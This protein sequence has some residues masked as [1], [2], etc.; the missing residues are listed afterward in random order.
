[1]FRL[2]HWMLK[3][4]NVVGNFRNI[5][6]VTLW[7][8]TVTVP[9]CAVCSTAQNVQGCLQTLS[10][11]ERSSDPLFSQWW[12]AT[13]QHFLNA[14][15]KWAG[16]HRVVPDSFYEQEWISNRETTPSIQLIIYVQSLISHLFVKCL[17]SFTH[18]FWQSPYLWQNDSGSCWSVVTPWVIHRY[19]QNGEL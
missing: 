6:H 19:P 5:R 15:S 4:F 1:M 16:I 11:T 13:Q 18:Q 3:T 14:A 7:K 9:T 10:P 2:S 12:V 8:A 17:S